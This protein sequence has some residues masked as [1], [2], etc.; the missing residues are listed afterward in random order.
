MQAALN[1]LNHYCKMWKLK[2]KDK[3]CIFFNRQ[4]KQLLGFNLGDLMVEVTSGHTDID[5][6]MKYNANM[7]SGIIRL[8]QVNRAKYSLLHRSI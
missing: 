2:I 7:L 8:K 6:Y 1:D 5:V 3:S 4:P